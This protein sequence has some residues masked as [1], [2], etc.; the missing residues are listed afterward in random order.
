LAEQVDKQNLHDQV[1]LKKVIFG[2][3]PHSRK[4]R[5]RFESLLGLEDSFDIPGL[6]ELYGPGTGLECK[7]HQGLHYWADIYILEILDPHTLKPVAPGEVGEMVV[8]T[9]KKEAAPLI[10][11]RTRDLSR[12]IAG[13]CPCGVTL[14]RHD[15][16]LGRSDDMFIFRGVNIYPGQ[17]ADVLEKFKEISSEYQIRLYRD[18]GLELMT[19]K[20]E[21]KQDT[22]AD[23][24]HNLAKTIS[25]ALHKKLLA[26]AEVEVQNP[27]DLPRTFAKTKRVL[28]ERYEED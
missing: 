9:L 8:T 22:P 25:Q 14:P 13:D 1:S 24:D 6:T 21:R 7:A 10:R 27:G 26:R 28:D 16:I 17:I 15:R 11:Y 4:M 12:L 18:Q 20:V 5:K 2:A 19:V 23:A 3:E